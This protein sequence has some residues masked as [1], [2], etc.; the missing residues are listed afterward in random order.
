MLNRLRPLILMFMFILLLEGVML[1]P[2][3]MLGI[4]GARFLV[5]VGAGG[6]DKD[7]TDLGG[8]NGVG[9][10]VDRCLSACETG[11]GTGC[12]GTRPNASQGCCPLALGDTIPAGALR[13]RFGS[14]SI[15][16]VLTLLLLILLDKSSSMRLGV[17]RL[18]GGV[19]GA[20]DN[21]GEGYP[22]TKNDGSVSNGG[23][24]VCG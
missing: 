24:G 15:F 23:I 10:E 5:M 21:D 4:V 6:D 12:N 20:C 22:E 18:S 7:G 2:C 17:Y 13:Y 8:V 9:R 3:I 16:P 1:F 14:R 19:D 11:G